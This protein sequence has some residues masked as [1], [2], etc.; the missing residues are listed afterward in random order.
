MLNYKKITSENDQTLPVIEKLYETAFPP[1]ERG[2]GLNYLVDDK[3]NVGDLLAFFDGERFVGFASILTCLNVSH[4]IYFAVSP[5]KRDEG[6]GSRIINTICRIKEGY[7]VI[8]DVEDP[9]E[10]KAKNRDQR[11]KRLEFYEKNGFTPT[12]IKYR[13]Q[14]GDYLILSHGGSVSRAEFDAFWQFIDDHD[15]D[16]EY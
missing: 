8:V 14:H 12:D 3:Q 9:E 16:L 7:K 10:E 13:W 5:D 15:R 2:R 6:Y 4:V 11:V 1:N